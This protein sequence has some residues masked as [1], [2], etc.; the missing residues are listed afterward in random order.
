MKRR[1][2]LGW[3]L[4][5]VASLAFPAAAFGQNSGGDLVLHRIEIRNRT[6]SPVT[7]VLSGAG[8]AYV[9]TAL[10]ESERIFTVWEG[11]YDQTTFACGVS[12]DGTLAV[13]QQIRLV[14]TSCPGP[15]PNQGAPSIEKVHL[16]DVPEGKKWL[17]QYKPLAPLPP[18]Q[19]GGVSGPC[20]FTATG[21]LTIYRLP[22]LASTVFATEGAG[23]TIPLNSQTADGWLG[24]DPGYAQAGNVGPF[25]NRWIPPDAEGDLSG[26]C[27]GLPVEWGPPAGVCFA[28]PFE[29]LNIYA[30]PDNTSTVAG[31][32][33]RDEF[34]GVLGVTADDLWAKV[35]LSIGST[36]A[37]GIGWVDQGAIL[38]QGSCG[39]LPV[40]SP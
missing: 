14:F 32:L 34:A 35:D 38:F 11:A 31:L 12:S 13:T 28:T 23:F 40:I 39:G 20:E 30:Q 15:A 18:V 2:L 26:D 5:L 21:D 37:L 27:S 9:L 19:D 7:V 17:Y 4:I 29:T 3:F 25:H 24:F 1:L 10:P 36:G 16:R 6:D 22:D 8:R 33:H